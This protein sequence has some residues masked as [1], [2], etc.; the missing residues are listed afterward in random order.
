[1]NFDVNHSNGK[2]YQKKAGNLEVQETRYWQ[3]VVN[4]FMSH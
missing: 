2:Y 1:M 4:I 3:L